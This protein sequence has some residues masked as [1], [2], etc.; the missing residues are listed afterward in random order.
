MHQN[1]PLHRR[2]LHGA[3]VRLERRAVKVACCVLRG[4]RSREVPDLPGGIVKDDLN[5][6]SWGQLIYG[7]SY[8]RCCH[9]PGC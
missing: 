5:S 7:P 8:T 4:E 3:L 9:Y 2:V 6:Q 1:I